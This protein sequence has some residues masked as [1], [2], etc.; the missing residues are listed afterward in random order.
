MKKIAI[1]LLAALMLFAFVACDPDAEE[2][3]L[4]T[5]ATPISGNITDDTYDVDV[6]ASDLQ[7]NIKIAED[8]KVTGTIKYYDGTGLA[9]LGFPED[10]HYFFAVE[11]D[12]EKGKTIYVDG[13]EN[14]KSDETQWILDVSSKTAETFV[15]KVGAANDDF[16]AGF[17]A[18]EALIT[19][20]FSGATFAEA[21][22]A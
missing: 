22:E 20:D 9:G 11:F 15:V 14:A 7:E 6:A 21:P 13:E 4:S 3:K 8:G 5:V 2:T 10:S 18:A 12:V 1:M 16:D 17:K 19:L